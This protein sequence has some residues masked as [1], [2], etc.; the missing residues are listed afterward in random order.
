MKKILAIA[1]VLLIAAACNQQT[2]N[3]TNQTTGITNQNSGATQSPVTKKTYTNAQLGISV[4]IMSNWQIQTKDSKTNNVLAFSAPDG[5]Q[6]SISV[7]NFTGDT[8]VLMNSIQ[9]TKQISDVKQITVNGMGAL[10]FQQSFPAPTKADPAAT[11]NLTVI[12][13]IKN[14]KLYF[15]NGI[16]TSADTLSTLKIQ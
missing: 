1:A 13:I 7:Q 15:I 14:S 6:G 12:A 16:L 8:S 9:K 4:E 3:T 10:S 2:S 11:K 5:Q